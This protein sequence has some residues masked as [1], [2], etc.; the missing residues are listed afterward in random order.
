MYTSRLYCTTKITD[1]QV[2]CKKYIH[3]KRKTN[4]PEIVYPEKCIT[5]VKVNVLLL[6]SK[7]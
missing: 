7:R 6:H 3:S 2:E 5:Y 4:R 1:I